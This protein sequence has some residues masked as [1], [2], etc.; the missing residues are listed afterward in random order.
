MF[1]KLL[2]KIAVC[3]LLCTLL[4]NVSTSTAAD[5]DCQ[6]PNC[7]SECKE[8]Y[9]ILKLREDANDTEII[10]LLDIPDKRTFATL[11]IRYRK[12]SSATPKLLQIV[13]DVND[14]DATIFAKIA[15]AKALCD[16]G[17]REWMPTIK[18]LST[19]PN[20]VVG[21]RTPQK[22]KVAGLLARAG[23]YSQF[24]VVA[25]HIDDNK[26]SV[27]YVA[28][29]ALGN[30]RHKTEPVTDLAAVLLTFTAIS[31]PVPW[32]RELAI[33]SLEKIAKIKPEITS[34]VINALEANIDSPDKNLRVVCRVK[35]TRYGRKL[36]TD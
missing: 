36:K 25:I 7:V 22:I 20:S 3:F 14:S 15:A 26:R 13:N 28:I 2:N 17:N 10:Q 21:R 19:D 34:R 31:D 35:L 9:D 11:L 1:T 23:D 32:L 6:D 33:Y 24:V 27:R 29:Q 16:F 18:A 30:F 12:I 8:L 5:S 4:T